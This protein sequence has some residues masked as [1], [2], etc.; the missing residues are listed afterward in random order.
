MSCLKGV[1]DETDCEVW[2]DHGDSPPSRRCSSPSVAVSHPTPES[3]SSAPRCDLR[4]LQSPPQMMR[5]G[6][7]DREQSS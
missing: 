6:I 2:R 3:R 7:D 5:Q 4:L 1:S